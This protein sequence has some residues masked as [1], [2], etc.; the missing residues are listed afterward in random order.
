[1]WIEFSGLFTF[2]YHYERSLLDRTKNFGRYIYFK[3]VGTTSLL[4]GGQSFGIH[5]LI[6]K[7]TEAFASY[8]LLFA[9]KL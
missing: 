9:H 1:M 3:I 6:N 7:G 4:I 8:T 5:P 2:T